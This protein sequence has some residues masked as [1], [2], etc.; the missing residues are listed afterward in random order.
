MVEI[1]S[2]IPE[3]LTRYVG[4][5]KISR[6]CNLVAKRRDVIKQLNETTVQM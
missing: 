6:E 1:G 4:R 3:R 2:E 5:Q